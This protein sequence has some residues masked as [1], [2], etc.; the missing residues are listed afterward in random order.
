[1]TVDLLHDVLWEIND[2]S[3]TVVCMTWLFGVIQHACRDLLR[4][5]WYWYACNWCSFQISQSHLRSPFLFLMSPLT[6]TRL[7][8][9]LHNMQVIRVI[10]QNRSVEP[11]LT[12]HVLISYHSLVLF[13]FTELYFQVSLLWD[14]C[15][16]VQDRL[17]SQW[18]CQ[19][20][21]LGVWH[22]VTGQ[23]VPDVLKIILS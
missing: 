11:W 20:S 3:V 7:N 12:S 19:R 22:C 6:W 21:R 4:S 15:E 10:V 17:F 13:W 16:M 9:I 23:V 18:C 8:S 1:V 2:I 5:A 14:I